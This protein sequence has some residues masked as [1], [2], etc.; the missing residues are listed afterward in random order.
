[1]EYENLKNAYG[2]FKKEAQQICPTYC[3]F[4]INMDGFKS[5]KKAVENL[6]VDAGILRCFLH[7]FIKIRSCGTKAYDL[8][9]EQ[10]ANRVWH[11]YH[12]ENKRSF[13]QRISNLESWTQQIVPNSPFKKSILKLCEKKRIYD[14]L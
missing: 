4:S 13:A 5:T 2:G 10:V 14:S 11:C 12:A 7:A 3:P 1:M 9:F 8:Y 6:F